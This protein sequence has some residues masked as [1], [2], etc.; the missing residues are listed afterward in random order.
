[1]PMRRRLAVSALVPLLIAATAACG[2]GGNASPFVTATPAVPPPTAVVPPTGAEIHE[3]VSYQADDGVIIIAEYLVPAGATKPPVVLLLHQFGGNRGQWASLVPKLVAAGYA[4]LGADLRS[5]G[6]STRALRDGREERYQLIDLDD[7]E[8]DVAAA[9]AWLKTRP[10]IDD[11]R[12]AVIGASVGANMAYVAAGEFPEVKT[13][14]AMSPSA[15]PR[16]GVLLGRNVP[17]FSPRSVLFMSDRGESVDSRALS[18]NVAAPSEVKVYD[19]RPAH[20]VAL[21]SNPQAVGDILSWL[22]RAL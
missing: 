14:I 11:G 4:V 13:A 12:I 18:R 10:E 19:D 8:K 17:G 3:R 21:L 16:G 5:F 22:S 6:Q 1:M 7:L 15:N 2:G 9:I 20:G